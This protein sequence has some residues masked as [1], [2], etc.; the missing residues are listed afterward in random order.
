MKRSKELKLDTYDGIN[1]YVIVSDKIKDA[2]EDLG[3]TYNPDVDAENIYLKENVYIILPSNAGDRVIANQCHHA[4]VDITSR[5]E[6][7]EIS[8]YIMGYLFEG[9]KDFINKVNEK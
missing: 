6:E 9:C 7:D 1:A 5:I 4:T 8:Y 3:F 2:Y